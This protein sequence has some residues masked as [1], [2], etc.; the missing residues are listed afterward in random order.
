MK[1]VKLIF[2]FIAALALMFISCGPLLAQKEE[3]SLQKVL[4]SKNLK[5][6]YEIRALKIKTITE[7]SYRADAKGSITGVYDTE[8]IDRYSAEGNLI[9]NEVIKYEEGARRHIPVRKWKSEQN[10][11]GLAET[12]VLYY[13][14]QKQGGYIESKKWNYEYD[15]KMNLT[16][17]TT[18]NVPAGEVIEKIVNKYDEKNNKIETA[19]YAADKLIDT[20]AYKYDLN[21]NEIECLVTG[22]DGNIIKKIVNTYDDGGI[23]IETAIYRGP[24]C[25]ID[26]KIGYNKLACV[27]NIQNYSGGELSTTIYNAYDDSGN[28][29]EETEITSAGGRLYLETY[30]YD[31][32]NNLTEKT[33]FNGKNRIELKEVYKY[34]EF[35]RRIGE[36]YYG[37]GDK[38][39][40]NKSVANSFNNLR[41]IEE[42]KVFDEK[43]KPLY[44]NTFSYEYNQ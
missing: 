21:K 26:K 6:I 24:G 12:E 5:E 19:R 9:E 20:T 17:Q 43:Q 1:N 28:K 30:A 23:K 44:K 27:V 29:T 4:E 10:A 42:S 11:N 36:F 41:R 35:N 39:K 34:D 38:L 31:Q 25:L 2:S 15:E 40:L 3:K 22:A 32:L 16:V 14:D 8:T 7:R 13:Y 18:L 37:G 33:R